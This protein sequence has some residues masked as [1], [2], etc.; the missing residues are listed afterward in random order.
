VLICLFFVGLLAVVVQVLV[1]FAASLAP[2]EKRGHAVGTVTSGVVR[3]I[4]LARVV[5]GALS[6]IGGWRTV[7]V[8]SSLLALVLT[9]A[10]FAIIPDARSE[11]RSSYAQLLRSA[12]QLR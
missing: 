10:L 6:D 2:L 8:T 3:G 5:A 11:M 9:G 1:A 4:L 12:E 7:Y